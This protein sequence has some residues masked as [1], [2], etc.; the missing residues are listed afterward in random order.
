M[1]R[2]RVLLR[3]T[4]LLAGIA[5]G[6]LQWTGASSQSAFSPSPK[7]ASQDASPLPTPTPV[8]HRPD[9]ATGVTFPQRGTAAY[10]RQDRHWKNG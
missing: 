3:R 6:V 7:Q 2:V 1:K 9:F 10:D 8:P 4:V 5:F